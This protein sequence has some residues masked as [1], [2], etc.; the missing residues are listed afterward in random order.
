M[1][2]LVV[3]TGILAQV[4]AGLIRIP[5]IVLLL[6]FGVLMGP[7]FWD[8]TTGKAELAPVRPDQLG[9]LLPAFVELSVVLIL[10]EGSMNLRIAELKRVGRPVRRLVTAGLLLTFVLASLASMLL[11]DLNLGNAMLFGALVSVTGPTVIRPL[12]ARIHVRREI[13]TILEGEGVLADPIGALLAVIALDWSL[14]GGGSFFEALQNFGGTLLAGAAVGGG[15]GFLLGWIVRLRVGY[16]DR[17]KNLIVLSFVFSCFVLAET[18]VPQSGLTSIVVCGLVSQHGIAAHEYELR[19]FKE[20][21]SI[22]VLSMLFILLAARLNLERIRTVALEHNGLWTVLL[23]MLVIRP[24]NVFMAVRGTQIRPGERIFLAWTAPRGIVAAA[25][26]SLAALILDEPGARRTEALVFLTIFLTV[27]IQG[28]LAPLLAWALR[29]GRD[30]TGPIL[31]VGANALGVTIANL[32]RRL[33]REVILVDRNPA[34][35]R[36]AAK[37]GLRVVPGD[38][39]DPDLMRKEAQLPDA[40]AVLALT[41]NF[42]VNQLVAQLARQERTDSQILVAATDLESQ[43]AP[44]AVQRMGAEIAFG[45]AISLANWDDL[46]RNGRTE[47]I[48]V[49]LARSRFGGRP[50]A[51]LPLQKEVIP[52]LTVVSDGIRFANHRQSLPSSGRLFVLVRKDKV[53]ELKPLLSRGPDSEG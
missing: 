22:L 47:L 45:R 20:Q 39:Q 18:C 30:A 3:L 31:I 46:I 23:V 7:S 14:R 29:L 51:D 53:A 44:E 4:L 9:D 33:G 8:L 27:F 52:L 19:V 13:R 41:P 26:A 15:M 32:L 11:S 5:S 2:V 43:I 35:C 10:F 1:L 12:M 48:E 16:S 36:A 34:V 50:A 37:L 17:L 24:L 42:G 38:A 6:T 21:L 40:D 25:V 49:D 28:G